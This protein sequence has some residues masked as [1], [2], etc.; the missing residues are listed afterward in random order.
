M[1]IL[2]LFVLL[3]GCSNIQD[4]TTTGDKVIIGSALSTIAYGTFDLMR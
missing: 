3:S 4:N 1:R 2:V